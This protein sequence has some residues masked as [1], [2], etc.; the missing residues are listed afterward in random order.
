MTALALA[1]LTGCDSTE[2]QAARARLKATRI[3]ASGAPTLVRRRSAEVRILAVT[4][5][6]GPAGTA[7][8][9]R[10]RSAAPRPLNDLPISVGIAGPAGRRMYL[11][12]A[13]NTDYFD[14]HL[15]SIGPRGSLT[16]VFTT[17]REVAARAAPF[18]VV[19]ARSSAPPT[20]VRALPRIDV[21]AVGSPTRS[22][23]LA[24]LRVRVINASQ[25]P[26]YGL[27]IY[28]LGL[29]RGRSVAAGRA[30]VGHLGTGASET[31]TL[32]LIGG[33]RPASVAL[34]ALPT[35]FQ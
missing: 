8:T 33:S 1:A 35:M 23:G 19:G 31:L 29:V 13:A 32:N 2:R 28:A 25:V 10:L 17:T 12:A 18:A 6:H 22:A 3:V 15:A 30:T 34:E 21:A 24:Q 7:I 27:Q 5:V 11:N 9:V 26:Q 20:T 14:T 16:W 4:L